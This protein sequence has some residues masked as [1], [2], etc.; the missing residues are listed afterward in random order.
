MQ[1]S[2]RPSTR[3]VSMRLL[4]VALGALLLVTVAGAVTQASGL[5]DL[6]TG[7]QTLSTADDALLA[8]LSKYYRL[9]ANVRLVV[10]SGWAMEWP[11]AC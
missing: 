6:L 10:N 3:S 1:N 9:H 5:R 11:G 8:D 7:Y 4:S 2:G